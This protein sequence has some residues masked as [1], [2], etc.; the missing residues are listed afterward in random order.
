[1]V[2]SLGFAVLKLGACMKYTVHTYSCQCV[3]QHLCSSD[4]EFENGEVADAGRADAVDRGTTPLSASSAESAAEG[5]AVA[6]M[7]C[8]FGCERQIRNDLPV[9]P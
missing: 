4:D 8:A 1:M 7:D 9:S 3:G 6:L 2:P 5:R